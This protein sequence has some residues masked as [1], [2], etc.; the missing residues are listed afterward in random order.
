MWKEIFQIL[1]TAVGSLA[2]LFL[3]CKLMGG[4]QISQLT[5]FDY[6]VGISIGSIAAELATELENPVRPALAM[7]IYGLIA[8]MISVVSNK[9]LAFR[10]LAEGSPCILLEKGC[11]SRENLARSKMDLSE[12]LTRC[13]ILGYFDLGDVETAVLENNGVVTVLPKAGKRPL[14]PDDV[15]V[16]PPQAH[17]MA[18]VVMDGVLR[19]TSLKSVGF[20]ETWLKN[21]LR[22]Q[23]YKNLS[24]VF[25]AQ[26]DAEGNLRVYPMHGTRRTED[27]F[28]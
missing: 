6:I 8:V 14:Q 7:L 24:Q 25:L 23:G 3:L 21:A 15:A 4:K 17:Y 9:W 16:F 10:R 1:L 20:E 13:R 26:L 27:P 19:P 5:M 18:S 11:I 2:I 28:N 22:T 12:F